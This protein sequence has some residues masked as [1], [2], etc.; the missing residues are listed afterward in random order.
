MQSIKWEPTV[1]WGNLPV[2]LAQKWDFCSGSWGGK[3]LLVPSDAEISA[4]DVFASPTLAA[5]GAPFPVEL[6]D[7]ENTV[8]RLK[9]PGV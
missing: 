3:Q 8:S 9:N 1:L 4:P 2:A 5:S 7:Y 6:P